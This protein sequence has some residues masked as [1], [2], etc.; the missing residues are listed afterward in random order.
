VGTGA[1]S[2]F[3]IG[4]WYKGIADPPVTSSGKSRLTEAAFF[5]PKALN[6]SSLIKMRMEPKKVKDD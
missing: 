4:M 3:F 2:A 1:K 6:G 5:T